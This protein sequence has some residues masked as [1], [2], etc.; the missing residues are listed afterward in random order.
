[1]LGRARTGD[2]TTSSISCAQLPASAP[3]L[4]FAAVTRH[5]E[6]VPDGV[7]PIALPAR[8]QELRMAWSLPRLLRQLAPELAHF[9]HALPLGLRGRAVVTLHDLSFE[10]DPTRWA[11]STA[12]SSARSSRARRAA[13]NHVLVVSERTSATS[14]ELYGV[15][16]G[17]GR[18]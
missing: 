13:P 12:S 11:G 1:M 5:P 10:R 14:I 9:Q 4:R 17:E 7:E 3:D 18:R 16:A 15:A 6:L 8:S 2:E